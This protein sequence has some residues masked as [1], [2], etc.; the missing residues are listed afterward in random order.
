M[1]RVPSSPNGLGSNAGDYRDTSAAYVPQA[2]MVVG[3]ALGD[4]SPRH[5]SSSGWEDYQAVIGRADVK[6]HQAPQSERRAPG[7]RLKHKWSTVKL[8]STGE[9]IDHNQAHASGQTAVD[10]FRALSPAS[11]EALLQQREQRSSTGT[12]EVAQREYVPS[13]SMDRVPAESVTVNTNAEP[14]VQLNEKPRGDLSRSE[15]QHILHQVRARTQYAM[16]QSRE[17]MGANAWS[18]AVDQLAAARGK[19]ANTSTRVNI[20]DTS[21]PSSQFTVIPPRRGRQGTAQQERRFQAEQD[22]E[23]MQQQSQSVLHSNSKTDDTDIAKAE[24]SCGGC[25]IAW[26]QECTDVWSNNAGMFDAAPK[27]EISSADGDWNEE[28]HPRFGGFHGADTDF[29]SMTYKTI[30]PQYLEDGP[31]WDF[32][33]LG[34]RDSSTDNGSEF[35]L[36]SGSD[37]GECVERRVRKDFGDDSEAAH[38]RSSIPVRYTPTSGSDNECIS[39]KSVTEANSIPRGTF[40]S[41]AAKGPETESLMRAE[42]SKTSFE[43]ALGVFGLDDY[44]SVGMV[45]LQERLQSELW[46]EGCNRTAI[47]NAFNT[48]IKHQDETDSWDLRLRWD[49]DSDKFLLNDHLGT[50]HDNW[51]ITADEYRTTEEDYRQRWAILKPKGWRPKSVYQAKGWKPDW[52]KHTEK[53]TEKQKMHKV[54]TSVKDAANVECEGSAGKKIHIPINSKHVSGPEKSI[55]TGGMQKVWKWVHDKGLGDK[56]GLQYTFGLAQSMHEEFVTEDVKKP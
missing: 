55:A 19:R 50:H 51:E 44:L 8:A 4:L 9:D 53:Q 54:D 18:T 16:K 7:R 47:A 56:I 11:Q 42:S 20:L 15:L 2:A 28:M 33:T 35:A 10:R 14:A 49:C 23:S 13:P 48:I 5:R 29:S 17:S 6:D 30:V 34:V 26:C 31:T 12:Q 36:A 22:I 43:Q 38:S 1:F 45:K 52:K 39:G 3:E 37:N 40:E 41:T 27:S 46:R 32:D 25:S 24:L 21:D